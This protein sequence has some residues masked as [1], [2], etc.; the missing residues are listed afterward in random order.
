MF[1]RL[2][3][4]LFSQSP[5]T[6]AKGK[7]FFSSPLP[8]EVRLLM[9]AAFA[10]LVYWL[11]RSAKTGPRKWLLSLRF[12]IVGLLM[13]I[14]G[15]PVMRV[16][17]P[18]KSKLFTA[19]LV[20]TSRSMSIADVKT[21]TGLVARLA[22]ARDALVNAGDKGVVPQLSESSQVILYAFSD[23]IHRATAADLNEANGS[24]TD[25]FQ[26]IR[27]VDADLRNV[28]LGAVVLVTDGGRNTGG[29]ASDA[30]KLL[31]ARGVPLYVLGVGDP[32]PPRDMEV[33]QVLNPAQVPAGSQVDLDVTVRHTGF[34]QPFDVVLKRGEE[35]ILKKN[36]APEPGSDLQRLRLTF[37][38]DHQGAA[39]Y[40][41][42]IPPNKEE[43]ITQ[44]N[45]KDFLLEVKDDRLPVLYVE[46]SPR[47]EY[48]F[49]RRAISRDP[50]FR[51]VGHLRRGSPPEPKWYNQSASQAEDADLK[52]VALP[53]SIDKLANYK[54]I[55]LGDIEASNFTPQQLQ[56]I[57]DFVKIRGGG[58]LML[59]GVN[60]FG[61]GGYANTPV[62]NALPVSMSTKDDAYS[63]QQYTAQ[64]LGSVLDHPVM[65]LSL[66][67]IENKSLWDN[68]P[69]L[70]GITPV[71]GVKPGATLLLQK[72]DTRNPVLAVQNYGQGRTAAF[73]S[74]GSWYWQVSR[75][76]SDEFHEKF[77][78]Q[79][80]RWL[81]VG[82]KDLLTVSTDASV[83]SKRDPVTISASVMGKDL[84]PLND[85]HVT[86][87]V[88]DALG[89]SQQ[90]PMDWILSE[91]GVY[92][93]RLVP[94]QQ[95]Q[96]QVKVSVEGWD[97]PP[98]QTAFVVSE[99]SL[100]FADAALKQDLLKDMA[101]QTH[102]EY[103]ELNQAGDMAAK[104]REG[105]QSTALATTVPQDHPIWD[106][107]I[108]LILAI[109]IVGSEWLI[110]RR[111]GL[112]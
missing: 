60:S 110:R 7:L 28:P 18:N 87:T 83:Y 22:A 59:G 46:G 85:A 97:S 26:S 82:A 20:D 15:A 17:E 101:E 50:T 42:E 51:L 1:T 34:D 107:P 92:Q 69:P 77:W 90:L 99:S 76:A 62:G 71:Q 12:A 35:I 66:D 23:Q 55:I 25:L 95:G 106:M 58:L 61:P 53:A 68:A 84:K 6:F 86:A 80:V 54:A 14:L 57:E 102:G 27:S 48:R 91:E 64:I 65:R 49:L 24:R 19:V 111:S 100:E 9:T 43:T 73:T 11:Y 4:F 88:T 75:P 41:L 21:S 70:I 40:H 38:P 8:G 72:P 78:K 79:L 81:A 47:M 10:A 37:T 63:D 31:Q 108:L 29:A 5:Q 98:A 112:S 93:C 96:Y 36:I 33:V 67:P 94:E 109:A 13:L 32:T 103:F 2:F 105:M 45:A 16:Q 44:N 74:G 104:I 30:A 89:N 56:M 52:D 39:A 3:Q